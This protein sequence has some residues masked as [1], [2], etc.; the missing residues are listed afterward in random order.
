MNSYI[1]ITHH[2]K[3]TTWSSIHVSIRITSTSSCIRRYIYTS[4]RSRTIVLYILLHTIRN[5][6]R[7]TRWIQASMFGE[8]RLGSCTLNHFT[9]H[10]TNYTPQHPQV[11]DYNFY[12]ISYF[13]LVFFI[14]YIFKIFFKFFIS[15]QYIASL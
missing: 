1:F 14:F 9:T 3:N 15:M 5:T 13:Y 8:I 11:L 10:Q 2:C 7:I 12:H 6:I 4:I